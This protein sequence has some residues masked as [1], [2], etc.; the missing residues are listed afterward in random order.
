M[1]REVESKEQSRTTYS[2]KSS[3]TMKTPADLIKTLYFRLG[4]GQE[5]AI[6]DAF[7]EQIEFI[8]PPQASMPIK[9]ILLDAD[10][11][12]ESV[13]ILGVQIRNCD[14]STERWFTSTVQILQVS[15]NEK[16]VATIELLEKLLQPTVV[17]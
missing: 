13:G 1:I 3:Q 17:N 5:W 7:A 11:G 14:V 9:N 8:L 10:Y 15:R 4:Q 2:Y 12:G 6:T 16:V